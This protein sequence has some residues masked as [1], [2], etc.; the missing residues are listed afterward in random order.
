MTS[1]SSESTPPAAGPKQRGFARR[2]WGK[3]A[4]AA[5][6]VVPALVF[7][8]WA[9]AALSFSYS[10]GVRVGFIQKFS[11]KGWLCKT[12]EGELAMVNMP[13]AMSQIFPFSVRNDSL[14]AAINDAMGKG[15]VELQYDQHPGVPTSCFG[16][17]QFFV[18]G[19]RNIPG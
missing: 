9:G 2:N 1:P 16:E 19:V 7:T 3:L 11:K 8:I 13:G 10:S 15:R 4:V 17:T 18:K 5:L 6:I 14:A 12:W